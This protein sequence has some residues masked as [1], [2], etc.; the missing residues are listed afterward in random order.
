[1]RPKIEQTLEKLSE[2][3]PQTQMNGDKNIWLMKPGHSGGGDDITL[4]T[5]EE[6]LLEAKNN[7]KSL[8]KPI[9]R[10]AWAQDFECIA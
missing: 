2:K 10:F 7:F 5:E 6:T 9:E 8:H 3:F 1:M 4:H